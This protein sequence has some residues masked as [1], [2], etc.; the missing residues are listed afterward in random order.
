MQQIELDTIHR[1]ADAIIAKKYD[2]NAKLT[3][4][5][6]FL[7]WLFEFAKGDDVLEEKIDNELNEMAYFIKKTLKEQGVKV[8]D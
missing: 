7:S 4:S 1:M 8:V 5:Y 2:E 3:K 6:G